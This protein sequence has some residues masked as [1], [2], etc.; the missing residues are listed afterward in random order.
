MK[1]EKMFT[2]DGKKVVV[3]GDLNQSEKIVQ[4]I[5]VTEDGSEI[6][7][8][9]KFLVKNLFSE[10]VKS[11][12]EKK[13]LE[14][15]SRYEKESKEWETKIQQLNDK[16]ANIYKSIESRVNWLKSFSNKTDDKRLSDVI[17]TIAMFL[18]PSKIYAFVNE[19]GKWNLIEFNEENTNA[20]LDRFES[21]YQRIRF[22]SM[23]LLSL[24]GGSD[25]S[26]SWRVNDYSDG[27]GSSKEV[28]FFSSI[29]DANLYLQNRLNNIQQYD[30]RVLENA[31]K[32]DLKLD[33]KKL[34]EYKERMKKE[35]LDRID[36]AKQS[37]EKMNED[38]SKIDE[39]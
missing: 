6:P 24:F 37:I 28:E 2:E 13:L 14:L 39:I 30:S 25:G 22:D 12:K 35:Y 11:W 9:E 38:M 18:S 15:E 16:K 4:E 8:G 23:R 34:S 33:K 3:I 19:Y 10:P 7:Q 21:S 31:K 1:A 20:L 29:E 5:F 17:N 36:A 32:Y 26:L 27:S